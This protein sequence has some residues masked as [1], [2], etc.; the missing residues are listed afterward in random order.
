MRW[1]GFAR[2]VLAGGLA[3]ALWHSTTH[4]AARTRLAQSSIVTHDGV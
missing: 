3:V 2:S 1:S 4:A